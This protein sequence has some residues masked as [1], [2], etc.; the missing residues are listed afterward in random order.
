MR[1]E[2]AEHNNSKPRDLVNVVS[3][4]NHEI[5]NYA[6]VFKGKNLGIVI[7]KTTAISVNDDVEK[8]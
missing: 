6:E 2:C 1:A 7:E 4:L 5:V 3:C 8:V